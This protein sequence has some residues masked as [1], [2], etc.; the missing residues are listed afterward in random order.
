M[1]LAHREQAARRSQ[2]G[3]EDRGLR[4]GGDFH[5]QALRVRPLEEQYAVGA[6]VLEETHQGGG[7]AGVAIGGAREGEQVLV[8]GGGDRNRSARRP[9]G[10]ALLGELAQLP[11]LARL[12][13]VGE[14]LPGRRRRG[15]GEGADPPLVDHD[16]GAEV[17]AVGLLGARHVDLGGVEEGL[18]A[19]RERDDRPAVLDPVLLLGDHLRAVPEIDRVGGERSG[20]GE[21]EQ[22]AGEQGEGTGRTHRHLRRD[23]L[24]L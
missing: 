23:R 13:Q 9:G 15:V 18:G 22:P 12:D 3:A 10:P 5:E 2:Q 6:G 4:G 7:D 14:L 19:V 20:D 8:A 11:S 1:L 24:R 17:A 21:Q 16:R